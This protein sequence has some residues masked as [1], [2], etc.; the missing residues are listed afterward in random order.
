MSAP[1]LTR[2]DFLASAAAGSAGLVIAL[3]LPAC[4]GPKSGAAAPAAGGELNAWLQI[5]GDN[6]VTVL[7]D[8]SE[9]GQ[10]VYTALPML[11][12]EELG[13][14]VATVHVAAAPVGAAYVN[15]G[16]TYA[17]VPS[18]I[19]GTSNSISDAWIRLRTAGAQAR[20]MLV[21]AAA[22][23]WGVSA[24]DCQAAQGRVTGPQGR[25]L[26]YGELAASA[27]RLPLPKD[28][29]LKPAAACTVIGRSAPRL[30]TP[31]KVDGSA[32]FGIDVKLPGMLHAALAQSPVLGGR[33]QAVD[34]A[35]AEK[36]PG[37]RKVL[38]C[39]Q[40]VLVIAD[41]YW[42]A[43][44]GRDALRITWDAGDNA[45]LDNASISATLHQAMLHAPSLAARTDGDPAAALK[46]A[47]RTVKAV[48]ELPTL[49]HAAMEPINCTA[50]VRADSCDLYVGTQVQMLVQAAAATA[51]GLPPDKV[52]VFTTLLGGSFGRRLEYD[53]VAPAVLAS[54]AVG[55]PVKLIWTREDDLM[56][57]IYRPPA[58]IGISGG[59]DAQGKL[60][61]WDFHATSPS[62]TS[63]Y[64]PANKDPFDSVLESAA[65]FFYAVPNVAVRYTR[66]ETG[67]DYGYMRSVSN[68]INC[69]AMECFV[70]ELAAAAGKD[71][72]QFRRSLLVGKPRHLR[73]LDEVA[74]QSGWGAAPAGRQLGLALLENYG[75]VL[76]EVAE[77][78]VEAGAVRVH[79]ITC[80][81]D[82]GQ[83]VNPKIVES[84]VEGGIVF[85]LSATLWGD[86]TVHQGQVQEQNFNSYRVLRSNEVP[87]VEVHLLP[88]DELPGG[89]GEPAVALV[90][91]AVC[92]AIHAATGTRLRRLP[93]GAQRL[94]R[95]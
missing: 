5:G 85:G 2:R 66:Q 50:D 42:Q 22:Q 34:S 75:T 64:D 24:A 15:A 94:S 39:P 59:F 3:T 63:R 86:I 31:A 91:P 68:A 43:I 40:G 45:Q 37:V 1:A 7:V 16:N 92:N 33:A 36:M 49:A 52:R 65:T 89:I 48:Y 74:R 53:Y 12:A 38:S 14:D 67:I 27:A 25:S 79:R 61:A 95:A 21:A 17:G 47:H 44:R 35:E 56:H 18:Q 60:D 46:R 55:H 78:S 10:G 20:T 13:I 69:F 6:T 32:R 88:S 70:D 11:L 28:V 80:V 4:S 93:I 51:A 41:H 30:D 76:A 23:T 77:V 8:R 87:A 29:A 83:V 54:K 90:A 19:T 84:Q 71:P 26:S 72:L 82:C 73:V 58:A 81:V 57:D 9:M 62:A